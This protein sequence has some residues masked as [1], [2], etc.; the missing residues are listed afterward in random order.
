MGQHSLRMKLFILS[1]L[2]VGTF[3]A[4][5]P[6]DMAELRAAAP[7]AMADATKFATD[8]AIQAGFMSPFRRTTDTCT[9]MT[10]SLNNPNMGSALSQEAAKKGVPVTCY[11]VMF[12]F[13]KVA[14]NAD[15]KK[16]PLAKNLFSPAPPPGGR[17]LLGGI[18]GDSAKDANDP[19]T[20]C[21]DP[22]FSP[23]MSSL[24]KTMRIMADPKCAPVFAADSSSSSGGRRDMAGSTPA[25]GRRLLG[26]ASSGSKTSDSDMRNIEVAFG[27]L[28]TKNANGQYCMKLFD[29]TAKLESA[30]ST[31]GQLPS[32]TDSTSCVLPQSFQTNLKSLGCCWNTMLILS[33]MSMSNETA[34]D[35][36]SF[37]SHKAEMIAQ[38]KQ[39]SITLVETPCG[40][41]GVSLAS[42]KS[43][44]TLS[45]LT[46]SQFDK[47]T[48]KKFE[49]GVEKQIGQPAGSVAVT[50]F[51]AVRRS[52]LEVQS[53]TTLV[54]DATAKTA[55]IQAKLDDKTAMT[56]KLQAEGGNLGSA[57]IS[58]A[59]ASNGFSVAGSVTPSTSAAGMTT[60]SMAIAFLGLFVALF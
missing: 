1:T 7:A 60:P 52:G 23:L 16:S 11:T 37:N 47:A 17:R 38:A 40:G 42:V 31:A 46:P 3:A 2:L 22:C 44:M 25:I 30:A 51:K 15:C 4:V 59:T 49:Q 41:G 5:S 53:T 48:Q 45:G 10:E 14:C 12:D 26:G 29:D 21:A 9:S 33:S 57:T 35:K 54:G 20:Q 43:T 8:F 28:C 36:V 6:A 39:C 27:L 58:S 32:V 50:S 56:T 13:M 19:T 55:D 34:A 18:S 24:V